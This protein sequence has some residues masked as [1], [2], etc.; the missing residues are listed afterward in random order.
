MKR[1]MSK[2][3]VAMLLAVVLLAG[4]VYGVSMTVGTPFADD[5]QTLGKLDPDF[6]ALYPDLQSLAGNPEALLKHY[7]EHGMAEGRMPYLGAQPGEPVDGYKDSAVTPLTPATPAATVTAPNPKYDLSNWTSEQLATLAQRQA[8][9][10]ASPYAKVGWTEQ[11][12]YDRLMWI[13]ANLYP[14][15]TVVGICSTGSAQIRCALYGKTSD[16]QMV[17]ETARGW[18][19]WLDKN[20]E[21]VFVTGCLAPE[22]KNYYRTDGGNIRDIR[23]G[24]VLYTKGSGAGHEAV[25]LSRDDKGITVVESNL[26]KDQKMH[27]GRRISWEKLEANG[28][29]SYTHYLY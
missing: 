21:P 26:N 23:V 10:D 3:I 6:Y 8:E 15:G 13:K 27:W 28:W 2:K 11:Q 14:E 9:F 24:D 18:E 19:A 12:V 20:D 4:V 16:W 25:V 22:T 17:F 7:I 29:L 1:F 5:S